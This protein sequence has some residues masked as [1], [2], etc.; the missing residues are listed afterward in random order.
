MSV[1]LSARHTAVYDSDAAAIPV[2][3]EMRELLRYR[4]LV[5]N[6]IVR[7]LKVRYKRSFLGFVWVMLNPLL[8]MAVLTIVFSQLFKFNIQHYP[9]FVLGGT[10]LW[11]LYSQG[12]SAA[13]ASLMGNGAIMRK[14]YVPPSVFVASAVGSALVNLGFALAPFLLLALITGLLPSVTWLYMVVPTLL[15]MIWTM[16]IG[17]VVAAMMV[18]FQDT[19]E[20]YQV[21][22][23]AFYF[24]TPVFYPISM[25]P[26]PLRALE[27]VNPLYLFI[28]SFQ[29]AILRNTLPDPVQLALSTLVAVAVL[30]VGWYFFTRAEDKFVYYF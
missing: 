26:P 1:K 17:L 4:F 8:T 5:W 27:Q 23:Q 28:S 2:I 11:N 30:A 21:L 19:F 25:L 20:I 6:L 9:V 14:L 10:L 15:V 3:H 22:L 18:F 7:D 13:M 16:G 12:S 29:N 24:L